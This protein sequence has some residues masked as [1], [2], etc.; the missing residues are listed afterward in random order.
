MAVEVILVGVDRLDGDVVG[1]FV[2]F[3]KTDVASS[4]G[5]DH[6]LNVIDTIGFGVIAT[7][8]VALGAIAVAYTATIL[9]GRRIDAPVA[10]HSL[11]ER[12]TYCAV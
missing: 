11:L 8:G 2:G 1:G 3:C 12:K 10:G 4:F 7:D 9:L 6:H 5:D